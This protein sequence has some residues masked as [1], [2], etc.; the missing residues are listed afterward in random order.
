MPIEHFLAQQDS[1]DDSDSFAVNALDLP[2][3]PPTA[4]NFPELPRAAPTPKMTKAEKAMAD[5]ISTLLLSNVKGKNPNPAP[6]PDRPL[7]TAAIN[8]PVN[9]KV[10]PVKASI[11]KGEPA[12]EPTPGVAEDPSVS[13][14]M[15]AAP[16]G[17]IFIPASI[18]GQIADLSPR[19][20]GAATPIM[21]MAAFHAEHAVSCPHDISKCGVCRVGITCCKCRLMYTAPA[22]KRMRC[23]KCLYWACDLDQSTG[24]CVCDTPWVPMEIIRSPAP[25]TENKPAA[26]F[27]GG[28]GS[29]N[30][31][32]SSSMHTAQ[33]NTTVKIQITAPTQESLDEIDALSR[34]STARPLAK[35]KGKPKTQRQPKSGQSSRELSRPSSVA[36]DRL[37]VTETVLHKPDYEVP[38]LA[39][40]YVW[41][42]PP[43]DVRDLPGYVYEAHQEK[44]LHVDDK[45]VTHFVKRGDTDVNDISNQLDTSHLEPVPPPS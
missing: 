36:S 6:A 35:E 37:S 1:E 27:R 29:D 12:P 28:A 19:P 18:R 39:H 44:T 40:E 38:P 34:P 33:D 14:R 23:T 4:A 21:A 10:A 45:D 30:A 3:P 2:L 42:P 24:C 22:A 15:T 16:P 17:M 11:H 5:K 25:A 7:S 20:S 9:V 8:L 43:A 26:R 41:S 32:E 31:S 13:A